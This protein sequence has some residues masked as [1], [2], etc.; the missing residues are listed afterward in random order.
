MSTDDRVQPPDTW[1]TL[2]EAATRTGHSRESLRQ[3][4]RRG[5]L[6]ATKG[7]DGMV[8]V[9]VRDLADLPPPDVSTDDHPQPSGGD[10]VRPGDTSTDATLAALV[11]TMDDLR[12]ARADHLADRGRA[13]AAEARAAAAEA[14]VAELLAETQRHAA[15][16]AAVR[17]D[18]A[19]ARVR[20][21]G[22]EGE[23]RA[24]REALA[25]ARRPA[26]R[27]WLGLA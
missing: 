13:E 21:A 22:A 25:E 9:N 6:P 11:A 4:V 7:N 1:L 23:A 2:T 16:L 8:R 19:D 27:R 3:R 24:L 26:W 15:E 12:T 18:H 17:Q 20:A 10:H 14:R 5:S